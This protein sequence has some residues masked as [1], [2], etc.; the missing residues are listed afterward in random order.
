M[1]ENLGMLTNNVVDGEMG[2]PVFKPTKSDSALS[3]EIKR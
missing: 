1:R 3:G 2:N